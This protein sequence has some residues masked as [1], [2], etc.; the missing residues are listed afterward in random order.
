MVGYVG[1]KDKRIVIASAVRGKQ[2]IGIWNNAFEKCNYLE[3]VIFEES[4]RY[5][6]KVAFAECRNLKRVKLPESLCEIEMQNFAKTF[7]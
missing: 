4:C 3:E 7:I 5:I 6:G 2:V 1:F